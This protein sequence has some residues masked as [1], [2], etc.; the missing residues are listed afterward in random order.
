LWS[1]PLC[2]V[3]HRLESMAQHASPETLKGPEKNN[4]PP[5]V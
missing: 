3:A 2:L 5:G 4:F 1:L